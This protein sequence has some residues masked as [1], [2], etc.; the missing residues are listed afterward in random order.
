MGM[1][2]IKACKL[3]ISS[4]KLRDREESA[5]NPGLTHQSLPTN[6]SVAMVTRHK[7]TN[8]ILIGRLLQ[9]VL[10]L[11]LFKHLLLHVRVHTSLVP[12][13]SPTRV[14]ERG[15]GVLSDFSC[16]GSPI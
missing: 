16:H 11:S 14:R 5:A 15:S 13:P 12:R 10:T 8:T 9:H 2:H 6:N 4:F 1:G 3:A 7:V